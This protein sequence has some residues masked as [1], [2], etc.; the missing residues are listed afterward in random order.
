MK[1]GRPSEQGFVLPLLLVVIAL[2]SLS[3]LS[4]AEV[5]DG[6]RLRLE[7]LGQQ[8]RTEMTGASA[9]ARVA[10]LLLTEPAS[11]RGL[12]VG[13]DRLDASGMLAAPMLSGLRSVGG[14]EVTEFIFDGRPYRLTSGKGRYIVELK[15]Q[16]EAGLFNLNSGDEPA[17]ERLLS[18]IGVPSREAASLAATLSDFVDGDD[19]RRMQGAEAG[20]YRRAG[21][22]EPRNAPLR[23]PRAALA[24]FGWNEGISTS[25]ARRFFDLA[26][27]S[28]VRQ[29][30][31]LN[32]APPAVLGAVLGIDGRAATHI[33]AER[34]NRALVSLADVT[35]V[36]GVPVAGGITEVTGIPSRHV[37]L[38]VRVR[39]RR[40]GAAYEYQTR[41]LVGPRDTDRPLVFRPVTMLRRIPAADPQGQEWTQFPALPNRGSRLKPRFRV[42][43]NEI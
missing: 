22:P 36:T 19:V 37:Q 40:A 10:Y 2:L 27:A 43:A 32:T 5:L 42:P 11:Q 4:A 1:S 30:L 26:A 39:D 16:D 24:A 20:N 18:E 35:A 7:R 41:L 38:R 13:G 15:V 9:E 12:R 6:S 34:E 21:R 31:N 29:R 8:L 23:S 17:M 3:I 14:H 28:P 33:V 25:Q